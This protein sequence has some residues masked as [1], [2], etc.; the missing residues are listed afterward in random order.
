MSIGYQKLEEILMLVEVELL[1]ISIATAGCTV[2][3]PIDSMLVSRVLF[4]CNSLLNLI[5]CS[6]A[7]RTAAVDVRKG[8][9]LMLLGKGVMLVFG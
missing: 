6:C 8:V 3:T 1:V 2:S 4:S 9:N 7:R 5:L